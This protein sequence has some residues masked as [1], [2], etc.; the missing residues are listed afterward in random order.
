MANGLISYVKEKFFLLDM[1][2][3]RW[4]GALM[5]SIAGVVLLIVYFQTAP[6]PEA[7][8]LAEE[9][10]LKWKKTE[11]DASYLDMRNALKKVPLLERKYSSLI[12]QKLFDRNRLSDALALA[13]QSL[14]SIAEDTPYHAAY[15]ETSLLIEQ[16]SYQ[17]ALEKA[18]TLKEQMKHQ[19]DLERKEGELPAAGSLLFA[20]N[21]LRIACLQKELKNRPGEKAAWED[22]ESFL[23]GKD[24]LSRV[25]FD[26]FRDKGLDLAHYIT[27]RKKQL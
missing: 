14:K 1:Q 19:C 12:A 2:S 7:Y 24:F 4:L 17:Q 15:G 10:V 3:K 8:A 5:A 6:G 16:G 11:D 25:V 22:L 26:N 13:Q 9:A 18:V 21:L 23:M 27:E 20:H